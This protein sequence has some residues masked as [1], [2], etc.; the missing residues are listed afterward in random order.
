VRP[1]P[2]AIAPPLPG[3]LSR[4]AKI[5]YW[6]RNEALRKLGFRDYKHYLA[7]PLWAAIR[8]YVLRLAKKC[9][10]CQSTPT[11]VHHDAYH[12][13]VLLGED[14]RY[15]YAVC[16]DCHR[17]GEYLPGGAKASP[18]Q[19]TARMRDRCLREGVAALKAAQAAQKALLS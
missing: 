12:I 15:L 1:R 3:D 10:F 2:R 17:Y 7:S 5:A 19:A 11:E 4:D 9:S 16:S 6:V 18:R 8:E 14:T 13:E